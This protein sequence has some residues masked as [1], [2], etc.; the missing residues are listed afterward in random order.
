MPLV[1]VLRRYQKLS[2]WSVVLLAAPLGAIAA[3]CVLSVLVA[4]FDATVQWGK[5]DLG[6]VL[7]FLGSGA[8]Y[9]AVIGGVFCLL[10]GITKNSTRAATASRPVS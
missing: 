7:V 9:G 3:V 6:D 4:F 5:V 1:Y 10:A 8:A 2:F